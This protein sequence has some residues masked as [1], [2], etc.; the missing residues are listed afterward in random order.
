MG[1]YVGRT[2]SKAKKQTNQI[3]KVCCGIKRNKTLQGCNSNCITDCFT[4]S[5]P[6]PNPPPTHPQSPPNPPPKCF[7]HYIHYGTRQS[8]TSYLFWRGLFRALRP[9]LRYLQV[10]GQE[11]RKIRTHT[12]TQKHA[13]RCSVILFSLIQSCVVLLA[14][15]ICSYKKKMFHFANLHLGPFYT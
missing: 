15:F 7:I 11:E 1:L 2:Q 12:I 6:C 13:T 8:V 9:L 4:N 10:S 3:L 5:K 14:C